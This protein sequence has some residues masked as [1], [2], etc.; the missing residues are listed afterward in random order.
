MEADI[1]GEYKGVNGLE[2][3]LSPTYRQAVHSDSRPS[4]RIA[5]PTIYAC[6]SILANFK[7]AHIDGTHRNGKRKLVAASGKKLEQQP[8]SFQNYA[9]VL[10]N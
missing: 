9:D 6:V 8:T 1:K 4:Q 5:L 7:V 2:C 3:I 10:H